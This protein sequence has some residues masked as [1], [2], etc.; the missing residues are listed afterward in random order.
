MNFPKKRNVYRLLMIIIAVCIL[1][2]DSVAQFNVNITGL[3]YTTTKADGTLRRPAAH[4]PTKGVF[5]YS[6]SND[7]SWIHDPL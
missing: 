6:I 5:P 2:D 1:E 3:D 4:R 7:Q